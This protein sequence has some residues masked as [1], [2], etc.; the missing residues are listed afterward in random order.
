VFPV[1]IT[2]L[3]FW[4]WIL[5]AFSYDS[6]ERWVDGALGLQRAKW[7]TIY[8]DETGVIREIRS[9]APADVSSPLQGTNSRFPV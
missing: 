2:P 7:P 9:S 1:V 4:G 6:S 5:F 3:F 8:A